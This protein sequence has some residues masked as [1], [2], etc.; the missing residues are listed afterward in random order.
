MLDAGMDA[1]R[2]NFS[3]GDHASHSRLLAALRQASRKCGKAIPVIQ[4]LQ[5]PRFR[6]G[7]LAQPNAD[8]GVGQAIILAGGRASGGAIPVRPNISFRGMKPGEEIV[9]GDSGILLRVTGARGN[10][11]ACRVVKGGRIRPHQ[12]VNFRHT[13][14]GLPSLTAKD[15]AD[16][17]FGIAEG[18]DFIALSF[19]RSV[20][21]IRALRRRMAGS[22]LGIIAKIETL[23]ALQGID[24]I[25]AESDAV[26]VARGD[27]AGEVS[28]SSVPVVQKFLIEQC[29]RMAKP[30]ITATQM[31]ESM[32]GNS[33]PTRAEASDVANAVID[34]SDALMLSGETAIGKYPVEAVSMMASLASTVE[35][36]SAKEWIRQRPAFAPEPHIDD[37]IAYLATHAA[38][39]L[40]AAAIITFTMSGSTALRVAKFRPAVPIFAVTPSARTSMRLAL[41][42]GTICE[43]IGQA[44]N[45]D[46]MIEMAI[47]AARRRGIVKRGDTV[48]VTAGVP[49]YISGKTNLVKLEVVS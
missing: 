2:L 33:Q 34:G 8:L 9:I 27:L 41:S 31:L 3:H 20:S 13:P 42:Y 48:A 44:R 45:T 16:L 21:D 1:A 38:H 14:A 35:L 15:L 36:A 37:T 6:I 25:I 5:G 32:I 11:L 23:Q 40:K 4:D 12:G 47:D 49:P 17:K 22:D 29:N 43:K 19:V 7:D 28:I 24:A 39:T 30:V 10:R 18:V 26:M 46:A